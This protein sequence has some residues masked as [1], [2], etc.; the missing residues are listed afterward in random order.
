MFLFFFLTIIFF[1]STLS[2]SGLTPAPHACGGGSD[3]IF[4]WHRIQLFD[5]GTWGVSALFGLCWASESRN[6]VCSACPA[7]R[8]GDRGV[9][10][11]HPCPRAPISSTGL[12]PPRLPSACGHWARCRALGWGAVSAQPGLQAGISTSLCWSLSSS[13]CALKPGFPV[14]CLRADG[15][16]G[17]PVSSPR[18][19]CLPFSECLPTH[20]LIWQILTEEHLCIRHEIR[21]WVTF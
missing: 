4:K 11:E 21:C 3:A 7:A 6:G 13:P 14:C 15:P 17:L 8:G 10:S 18:P 20:L 12:A 9:H 19:S 16:G 1:H 2:L 5:P